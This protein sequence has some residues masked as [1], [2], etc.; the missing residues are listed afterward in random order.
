M[1]PP[2]VLANREP[3]FTV[4]NALTGL[5]L[6]L[7]PFFLN[8]TWEGHFDL[9]FFLFV[10]AGVTDA[11]DGYIARK[12]NQHSRLGA[13][14]DPAAD[15]IMMFSGYALYTFLG[16]IPHRMPVWLTALLFA[17]DIMIIFF[18]YLLYTRINLKRF[19]PSAAGKIAT[20]CQIVAL[21]TTIAANTSLL[22]VPAVPLLPA[23]WRITLGVTFYSAWDYLRR[24]EKTLEETRQDAGAVTGNG[25]VT[26][27][28]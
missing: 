28:G 24:G 22:Q 4:P 20:I 19:P 23:V 26:P 17:R 10:G 11:L 9:A 6:L 3:L 27:A 7:I 1:S 18:A 12:Y 21:S 15:K 13:I 14:L 25:S 8:A 5:R 2:S 16:T